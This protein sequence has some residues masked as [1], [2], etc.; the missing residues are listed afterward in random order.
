MVNR[1]MVDMENHIDMAE[2]SALWP[3]GQRELWAAFVELHQSV[4]ELPG[5]DCQLVCRPGVSYSLRAMI[6]EPDPARLRPVFFLVDVVVS[7][8]DPW[9]LSVCFYEDEI[10]DPQGLGNPV[11]QGLYQETGYCFDLE[12]YDQILISYVKQ[13]LLEAFQASSQPA[14]SLI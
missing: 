5:T 7:E 9:F 14:D 3:Q 12:T 11:P 10:S 13:R 6:P 8:V 1:T 4:R 2:L